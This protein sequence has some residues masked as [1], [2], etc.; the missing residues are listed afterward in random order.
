MISKLISLDSI[1][2]QKEGI[3]VTELNGEKVMMDLDKG[4]YFMLE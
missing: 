2:S 3:D 4:K 1:V